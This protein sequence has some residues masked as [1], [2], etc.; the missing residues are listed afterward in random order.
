MTYRVINS[1]LLGVFAISMVAHAATGLKMSRTKIGLGGIDVRVDSQ[2]ISGAAD[3]AKLQ[4][5][6]YARKIVVGD[7]ERFYKVH[8]PPGYKSSSSAPV[9]FMFHGGGG[10]PDAIRFQSGMDSLS[11][12]ESFIVVYPAGTNN[13][14]LQ[15]RLLDWN[16]GR[17]YQ[18]GSKSEV[19]DVAFVKAMLVELKAMLNVDTRRIYAAGF[20]N[21]AQFSFRLA[22]EMSD[23]IAAIAA[24]AGHRSAQEFGSPACPARRIPIMQF[25]GRQDPVAP[26]DGGSPSFKPVF[27]T[28]LQ[29]VRETIMTWVKCNECAPTAV[30]ESRKGQALEQK[31][32]KCTSNAPVILWTLEDGGHT[33]PGGQ[34]F[35]SEVK[36]GAGGLNKDIDASLEIWNFFKRNPLPAAPGK[37]GDLKLEDVVDTN[38]EKAAGIETK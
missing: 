28:T 6:D 37:V 31:W 19:D 4:H 2:W 25:A 11:D 26:F 35:P 8:V 34:M 38:Q 18:D 16:D 15:D 30:A 21:G 20:S 10:Y 22:R 9:V 7:R 1:I 24:V 33:W 29:P 27:Q 5:G 32:E 23:Q 13:R 3:T 12:K 14:I 17:V 36:M